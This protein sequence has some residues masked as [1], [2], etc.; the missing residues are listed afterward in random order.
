MLGKLAVA[1]LP[2]LIMT[3]V[4]GLLQGRSAAGY[5]FLGS[6]AGLLGLWLWQRK[7]NKS[8]RPSP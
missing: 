4:A 7:S 5:T 6:L 3:L 2:C 8:T 1:I